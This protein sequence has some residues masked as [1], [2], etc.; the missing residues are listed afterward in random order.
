[1]TVD[2]RARPPLGDRGRELASVEARELAF[3]AQVSLRLEVR[4]A[5]GPHPV[6]PPTAPNTWTTIDGRELL[7]LGPDEWLVVGD[8]GTE[9]EIVGWLDESFAG[10]HRSIVDVSSNRAALELGGADRLDLLAA[11]CGLDLHPRIWHEG[12]CAQTLV[13]RIPILLQE[14]AASTRVFVR[15][16]FAGALLDWL[17]AFA[18]R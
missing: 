2:A 5:L 11:G 9:G 12:R 10:L 15:S 16:S 6:L 4:E 1:V 7:W 13:G 8:P 18:D 17:R 3:L 14:R